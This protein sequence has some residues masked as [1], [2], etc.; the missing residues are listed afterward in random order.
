MGSAKYQLHILLAYMSDYASYLR[1]LR[2]LAAKHHLRDLICEEYDM[3]FLLGCHGLKSSPRCDFSISHFLRQSVIYGLEIIVSAIPRT[4]R[5]R[6]PS[7]SASNTELP[8][9]KWRNPVLYCPCRTAQGRTKLLGPSS[10]L[11]RGTFPIHHSLTVCVLGQ[12]RLSH[13]ER[14]DI[15]IAIEAECVAIPQCRHCCGMR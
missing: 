4:G 5:T 6:P 9:S 10:A 14:F 3:R 1:D 7:Q 15:R 13:G 12:I 8:L 2:K 11:E